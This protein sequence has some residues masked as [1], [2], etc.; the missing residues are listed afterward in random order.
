M[1]H[2]DFEAEPQR[3][4]RPPTEI[5]AEMGILG[6]MLLSRDAIADVTE[7]IKDPADFYRPA[8]QVIFRA[9]V[10]RYNDG[11]PVD[12]IVLSDDLT[13]S[14]DIGR[15]GGVAYLHHLVQQVPTTAHAEHYAEIVREK[16]VLRNLQSACHR[17][18]NEIAAGAG[19]TGELLDDLRS[20]VD[21]I[22]DDT[23][24]GDEDTLVGADGED[25]LEQLEELQK[26]GPARGVK[27]GF[28]DFDTL[29]NG[30]QPG[31][32][33]VIA[34]RPAVGKSTLGIDIV[35]TAA[36]KHKMAAAGRSEE[37]RVGKECSLLCRSRWSPYH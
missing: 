21:G 19:D 25:F 16:A 33:I 30:L 26:N 28:T 36:I 34:A 3:E 37:R 4:S 20:E 12:P 13:R 2:D 15:I 24:R 10:A 9:I 6:A 1:T 23:S 27:T 32:L 18:L 35:R 8:H 7:I 14:G 29:T 31:Q 5:L 11:A 22:V 17:T